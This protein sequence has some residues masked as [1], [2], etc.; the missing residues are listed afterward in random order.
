MKRRSLAVAVLLTL[1]AAGVAVANGLPPA[2]PE[3]V[4]LSS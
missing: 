2:T 1:L 4:G 3:Q